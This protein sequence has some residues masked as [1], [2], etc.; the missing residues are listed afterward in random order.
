MGCSNEQTFEEFFQQEMKQMHKG[1]ENYSFTLV[2]TEL[3][4]IHN[5][6]AIAIFTEH[7]S[8]QGE[9]IYI[10]YF[11]K[12]DSQWKWK[13]T[14][15]AEWNIPVKWSSMHRQPYIY[16]GPISDNTITGVYVGEEP[17]EILDIEGEK[18][19]WYAVNPEE[20]AEIRT[21]KENGKTEVLEKI[22]EDEL[23]S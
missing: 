22:N 5:D 10:A 23:G 11:E 17:A 21:V 13:E 3:N 7:N 9:Q 1:E 12:Q 15:G 2:H 14:R 20:N 4:A 8:H 18:R 16:S 6:D 19:F